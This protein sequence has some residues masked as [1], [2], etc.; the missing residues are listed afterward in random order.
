MR[1]VLASRSP[2][3]RMLLTQLG[4]ELD[5]RPSSVVEVCEGEPGAVVLANARAKAA[6]GVATMAN[7]E[8]AGVVVIGVDTV[9]ALDGRIHG[10]PSSAADAAETLRALSGR[11]HEVFSGVVVLGCAEG[12]R[13][14]VERTEVDFRA[15]DAHWLQWYIDSGE[16][17]ERAGGYAIQGRGAA[18]VRAVRG[19]WT[20]VVGLPLGA[21]LE[22]LPE[23]LVG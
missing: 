22:L 13:S 18:L 4:V 6:A 23:L 8:T 15:L 9:V 11:T 5:V 21:L 20:N 12:E 10:K 14:H 3:R 16:W 19:D 7:T 1:L 17:R 2:Q